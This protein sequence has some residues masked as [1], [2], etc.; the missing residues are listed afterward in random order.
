MVQSAGIRVARSE[1]EA[2]RRRLRELGVLRTDL[3]VA[4]AGD[5]VIFPVTDS[6]GPTLPT[7]PF[8]FTARAVQPRSYLDLLPER[9]RAAAPRSFDV[10]GDIVIVKIP[11]EQKDEASA[12]GDALLEFHAA[13]AVFHDDGVQGPFRV[14]AL[15]RIAGKGPS[16]TRVT[17]NG[18]KLWVDPGAA[19]FSPRLATERERIARLVRP[20]ESVV[21]LFCG[22]G[23]FVVACAR[24]GA[25]VTGIDLNPAA[26]ELARRN[27]EE[28]GTTA[29]VVLIEGDARVAS[30]GLSKADRVILNLP[31]GAKDFLDVARRV[32]RPGGVVHYHEILSPSDADTRGRTVAN[33]LGGRVVASRQVRAYSP[34]E[35]H[36]VFDVRLN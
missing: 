19:Y 22:V 17:E 2:T 29:R 20:D 32:C 36:R 35:E 33:E 4:K 9:L 21:D 14:R 12:I 10:L 27:V 11:P 3:D 23:P 6:C 1:A 5:D 15:R 30:R 31:H 18:A 16:L 25:R 13:R 26:I 24:A 8:E 7:A 34:S 28:N